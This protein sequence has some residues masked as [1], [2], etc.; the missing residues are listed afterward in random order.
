MLAALTQSG[1]LNP[2]RA[3]NRMRVSGGRP[4]WILDI[5]VGM[6]PSTNF[7]ISPVGIYSFSLVPSDGTQAG[8]ATRGIGAVDLQLGQR[9]T[10][11]YGATGTNSFAGPGSGIASGMGSVA[12]SNGSASGV[13][14]F[15][16]GGG[17]GSANVTS[18]NSLG[19]GYGIT[20]NSPANYSAAF[21]FAGTLNAAGSFGCGQRFSSTL[22][23]RFFAAGMFA[24][25]ADA[26]LT[27][28]VARNATSDATPT[29]LFLD[30]V[31]ARLVIPANTLWKARVAIGART[32]T[33]GALWATFERKLS[34]W[35][36]VAA[37]TVVISTPQTIGT[38]EGSTAGI[39]PAGWAISITA[40]TTNGALDIQVTGALATNI[41]WVATITL[42]EVGYP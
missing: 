22:T 8:G 37:G 1:M 27:D 28:L 11:N 4:T 13:A 31:S 3:R 20:I 10:S 17:G 5:P 9:G 42:T 40:D 21:G 33:A 7:A 12:F 24:N 15:A 36:G 34:I 41:R 16:G 18:G 14:S 2:T 35:R 39:P 23:G 26:Q 38:D 25:D 29:N 32:N 30:G 6:G 19:W